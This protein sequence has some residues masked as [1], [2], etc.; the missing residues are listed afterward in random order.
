MHIKEGLK[1]QSLERVNKSIKFVDKINFREHENWFASNQLT[2]PSLFTDF[3][4]SG[5][6]L[7]YYTDLAELEQSKRSKAGKEFEDETWQLIASFDQHWIPTRC[8]EWPW[9]NEIDQVVIMGRK[10]A[11]SEKSHSAGRSCTEICEVPLSVLWN[12][13][14][15]SLESQ[16]VVTKFNYW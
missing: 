14:N 12:W 8:S 16:F 3:D 11:K 6:D 5:G 15:H 13:V 10:L 4:K 2:S 1:L 9:A 7:A